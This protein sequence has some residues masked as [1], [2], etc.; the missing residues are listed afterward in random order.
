[1]RERNR[2]FHLRLTEEEWNIM[3]E[4]AKKAGLRPQA[5]IL[6][7]LREESISELSRQTYCQ[8]IVQLREIECYLMELAGSSG[9]DRIRIEAAHL[10]RVIDMLEE[11]YC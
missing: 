8:A 10:Q 9:D 7:R 2:S 1:M 5:L 4:S 6:K 3:E 11:A